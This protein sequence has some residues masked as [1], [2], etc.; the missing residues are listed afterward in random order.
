MTMNTSNQSLLMSERDTCDLPMATED[1]A[2]RFSGPIGGYFLKMQHAATRRMV[3]RLDKAMIL[4]LGGAHGQNAPLLA[5][6][7]HDV[8]VFGSDR[9]CDHLLKELIAQ[10][11]CKFTVGDFYA[12][13]YDDQSFDLVLTYRML[14]HVRDA[15]QYLNEATRVARRAVVLE[16]T[17]SHSVNKLAPLLFG[18]K[19]KIEGNTREYR[20]FSPR[21]MDRKMAKRGFKRADRVGQFFWPMV[22]HRAIKKVALSKVAE[23]PARWLGLTYFFGSPMIVMYER[24][25]GML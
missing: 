17:S 23:W 22:L 12:L 16:F 15:E 25:S 5:E 24:V 18:T 13:P 7:G 2:K 8:T 14:A 1:Y 6:L 20:S 3:R 19:R 4:S 10:G 9:R 11:R 21:E